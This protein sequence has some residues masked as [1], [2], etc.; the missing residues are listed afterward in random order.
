MNVMTFCFMPLFRPKLTMTDWYIWGDRDQSS[1]RLRRLSPASWWR[2]HTQDEGYTQKEDQKPV[3]GSLEVYLNTKL[4]KHRMRIWDT[5][6]T[7]TFWELHQSSCI[8]RR[9]LCSDPCWPGDICR[10]LVELSE[11]LV[12]T[13]ERLHFN[14]RAKHPP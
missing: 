7:T 10:A 14:S 12:E 8:A 2:L 11:H 5:R 1:E 13:L 9:H 4:W 6:K 3:W